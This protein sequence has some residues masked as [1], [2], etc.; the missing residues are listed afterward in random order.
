MSCAPTSPA[1]PLL[2]RCT[3]CDVSGRK[4]SPIE[5]GIDHFAARRVAGA[6]SASFPLPELC[7]S[8]TVIVKAKAPGH[9]SGACLRQTNRYYTACQATLSSRQ[10]RRLSRCSR[11]GLMVR[12]VRN[13]VRNHWDAKAHEGVMTATTGPSWYFVTLAVMPFRTHVVKLRHCSNNRNRA[14][15]SFVLRRFPR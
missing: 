13:P 14:C 2:I 6:V 12:F 4:D 15:V 11:T 1:H 5:G 9:H 7:W 10:H 3:N 8:G